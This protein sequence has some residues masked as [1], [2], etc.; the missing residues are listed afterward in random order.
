MG[1]A[2]YKRTIS[3]TETPRQI[4]RR[5]LSRATSELERLGA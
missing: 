3:Q 2:A 4:E 5:V 1:I